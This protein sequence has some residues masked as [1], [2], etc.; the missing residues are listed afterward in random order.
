MTSEMTNS[1]GEAFGER[2]TIGSRH[3]GRESDIVLVRDRIRLTSR[4]LGFDNVTQIKLTTAA[5]EL[6]RN[7]FEY[8]GKGGIT[9]SIVE[10]D[11]RTGMEV[12]FEDE[13]PGI[14]DVEEIL[15]GQFQSRSGLGKGIIGSRRLMDEFSIETGPGLG[16][17]IRTVKWF[18]QDQRPLKSV[19]EI[20]KLFFSAVESGMVE[21]LQSQN[22]E[23]VRVLGELTESRERLEKAN[24]DLRLANEK[25]TEVDQMKSRFISTIAHEVR[26][27]LNAISGL[28]QVLLRDKGEPLTERQRET[29]ERL[30]RSATMLARLVNDLLDLSRLQAGRMQIRLQKFDAP[31]LIDSVYSGLKQTASDKGVGFSYGVEPGL[32]TVNSDPT[33]IAQVITNLASNAIKFTPSGG[34]VTIRAGLDAG[35][36]WRI[37]VSDTGIGIAEDQV[38][39]IFEEFRQVNLSNPHHGGGTGLGLPISKRLVELLGG[40]LKVISEPGHGSTFTVILPLDVRGYVSESIIAER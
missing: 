33:K 38:P 21:E 16:T 22:R 31:E 4:E 10:E 12:L 8:A 37:E 29:V 27:P 1:S 34:S 17:R 3:V 35:Q 28:I 23:L 11:G 5:S 13:G 25:L 15:S 39:L 32:S 36:M 7:I 19:D 40:K 14:A 24:R 9:V 18:D 20:R 26:T 2:E 6:T 30:D